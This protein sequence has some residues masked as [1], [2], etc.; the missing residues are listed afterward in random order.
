MKAQKIQISNVVLRQV[1]CFGAGAL[2]LLSE[3]PRRDISALLMFPGPSMH[4]VKMQQSQ[5]EMKPNCYTYV[6]V[7]VY[8]SR[9]TAGASP[10][11]L[12]IRCW[13]T[14]QRSTPNRKT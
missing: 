6:I 10:R 4:A 13:R 9:R 14:S 7:N 1:S 3:V 2:N 8:S 5:S 11:R 12:L